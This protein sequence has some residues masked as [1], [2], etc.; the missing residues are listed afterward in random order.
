MSL[1]S[2]LISAY[3]FEN[4][5]SMG[6]DASGN[7]NNLTKTGSVPQAAGNASPGTN[8]ASWSD[9]GGFSPQGTL[10]GNFNYIP[11][12]SDFSMVVWAYVL[13]GSWNT[14]PYDMFV[15]G[16]ENA[17]TD[18]YGLHLSQS[19]KEFYFLVSGGG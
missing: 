7:G 14:T 5:G 8:A 13:N 15:V 10:H 4:S 11:A 17:G 9:G 3:T 19:T 2:N 12:A 18:Q 1:T 16:S 6:A